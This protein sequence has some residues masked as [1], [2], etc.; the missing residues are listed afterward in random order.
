MSSALRKPTTTQIIASMATVIVMGMNVSILPGCYDLFSVHYGSYADQQGRSLYDVHRSISGRRRYGARWNKAYRQAHAPLVN[1]GRYASC[2]RFSGCQC[3]RA[4]LYCMGGL[5]LACRFWIR[6]WLAW[7]CIRLD[8]SVWGN[9]FRQQVHRH[10]RYS[11]P[12]RF[13]LYWSSIA[14]LRTFGGLP[15]VHFWV[16][17]ALTLVLG[18]GANLICFRKPDAFVA[19][20]LAGAVKA[21]AIKDAEK[22]QEAASGWSFGE[23]FKHSPIY[24]FTLAFVAAA[25]SINGGIATFS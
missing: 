7:C 5:W 23:S 3:N 25:V 6:P 1:V 11:D 12:D 22:P 13:R 9:G 24:L 18:G 16:I 8:A 15:R 20:E 17:A 19:E 21:Q 10:S 4:A 14:S 2:Y